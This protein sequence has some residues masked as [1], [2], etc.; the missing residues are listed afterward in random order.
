MESSGDTKSGKTRLIFTMPEPIAIVNF[1]RSLQD[2]LPEFPDKDFVVM[3]FSERYAGAEDANQAQAKMLE[4]E[5][6]AGLRGLFEHRHVKSIAVDKGTTLW[7]VVRVAEWG[8][9][10]NIKAHHYVPV[11]AR[12]RAYMSWYIAHN[13]N[14]MVT[15]DAK[16]EWVNEKPT[17]RMLVDGFKYTSS[18]MQVNVI[19]SREKDGDRDFVL[20]VT[21][22]GT[23]A[24]LVGWEFKG[25]DID[26]KKIALKAMDDTLPS[27]WR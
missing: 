3:D 27:D 8:R 11:N 1:D 10:S 23:N 19:M 16:E 6:A 12:M 22:C 4:K 17:G 2:I 14:F 7:E 18:L 24:D 26:F 5:F 9:I 15:H 20:E 21:G 13:K 25:E